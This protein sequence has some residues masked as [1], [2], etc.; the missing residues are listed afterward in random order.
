MTIDIIDLTAEPFQN[1]TAVQLAMVRAAQAQKDA[2]VLSAQ[3]EKEKLFLTLLKH[4]VARHS[5]LPERE[6][7]IDAETERKVSVIR[8]D[9]LYQLAYDAEIGDGN[10]MG[11]YR[12]PENPNFNLSPSQ[13]FIVVRNYYMGLTSNPEKRLSVYAADT[14][15]KTYLGDYYV[16][17]YD[18]LASYC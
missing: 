8:E 15:A 16:T 10:E 13:R 5:A 2:I 4:N 12:Y 18:L 7:A 17:L 9:L 3:S 6:K 14:L 11:E 1:L